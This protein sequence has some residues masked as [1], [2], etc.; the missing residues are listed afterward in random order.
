MSGPLAV[1]GPS[2]AG[3]S[4]LLRIVAGLVRPRAGEIVCDGEI[5]LGA[6]RS[7]PPERRAVGFVFQDYALFPHLTV[8][9]NV[10]FGARTNPDAVLRRI[11]IDHLAGARPGTLSGG[12]RQRVAVARAIA[13]SPRLLLLD[14]PLAALDVATRDAVGAELAALLRDAGVPALIVTHSFAEAAALA[15][16][17]AVLERGRITQRGAADDLLAEPATAF[18]A[19]FAGLNRLAGT[20]EGRTVALDRG[21]QVHLAEPAAGR[22]SVLVAPW[23]ITLSTAPPAPSSA[24]NLLAATVDHVTLVGDRAR[25]RAGGLVAEVTADSVRR[26]GLGPGS[27]VT[28][29]WKATA[30]RSLPLAVD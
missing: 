6:G 10:A 28:A 30:T 9:G 21:G 25:V 3:K 2:G 13:R 7:V 12:E 11:G 19:A 4:T 27:A 24:Q 1:V 18:V 16:R 17:M 29:S 8:R 5:W 20:A 22:V 14:E 23:E 15:P 26:L